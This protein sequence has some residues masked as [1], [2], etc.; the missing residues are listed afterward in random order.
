[1]RALGCALAPERRKREL[2]PP[3]RAAARPPAPPLSLRGLRV[4]RAFATVR[5]GARASPRARCCPLSGRGR[6]GR[7]GAAGLTLSPTG[8]HFS[9]E[10]RCGSAEARRGRVTSE[11]LRS[12]PRAAGR[13]G[14]ALLLC[15]LTFSHPVAA[16]KESEAK[17]LGGRLWNPGAGVLLMD[18]PD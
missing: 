15:F 16:A 13:A 4:L 6:G 5:A 7:A 14:P 17:G 11:P 10:V 8:S 12:A 9:R 3:P 18:F 1:M 2:A